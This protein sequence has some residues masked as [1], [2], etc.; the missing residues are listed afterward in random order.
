MCK[1]SCE[2]VDNLL[3]PCFCGLCLSGCGHMASIDYLSFLCN[4]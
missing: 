3:I 2:N 4:Y 1:F